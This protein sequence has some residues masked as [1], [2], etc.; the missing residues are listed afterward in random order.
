VTSAEDVHIAK[1]HDPIRIAG[2]SDDH[3]GK[4]AVNVSVFYV[5]AIVLV[6]LWAVWVTAQLI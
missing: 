6:V 2:T 5:V 3:E 4:A 1:R